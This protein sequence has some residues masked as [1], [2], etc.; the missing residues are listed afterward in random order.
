MRRAGLKTIVALVAVGGW[1]AGHRYAAE[2]RFDDPEPARATPAPPPPPPQPAEA[3]NV[4]EPLRVTA[5]RIA[6]ELQRQEADE[7]LTPQERAEVLRYVD[8]RFR[9]ALGMLEAKR[10]DACVALC[11]EILRLDAEYPPAR[12]LKMDARM[13]KHR[14]DDFDR[15]TARFADWTLDAGALKFPSPARWAFLARHDDPEAA[16]SLELYD[17]R[18]LVAEESGSSFAIEVR[19]AA[20]PETSM[21]YHRG[22]LIVNALPEVHERI[23]AFLAARRAEH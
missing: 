2:W 10:F 12:A 4:F 21:T 22:V 20:A 17:V 1:F 16:E 7:P 15:V 18:D 3:A 5:L 14:P 6:T 11:G 13:L 19:A 23:A 9:L 8:V